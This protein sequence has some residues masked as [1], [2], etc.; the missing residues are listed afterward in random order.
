MIATKPSDLRW[1]TG[2]LPPVGPDLVLLAWV[3]GELANHIERTFA[4]HGRWATH[5]HVPVEALGT[6]RF[7]CVVRDEP[8]RGPVPLATEDPGCC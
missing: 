2:P 1:R 7:W 4:S 6:V 5:Y 3:E 8:Y